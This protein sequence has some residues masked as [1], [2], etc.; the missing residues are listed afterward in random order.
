VNDC[1][2]LFHQMKISDEAQK[3]YD[4]LPPRC[5]KTEKN[6]A[7]QMRCRAANIKTYKDEL[8]RAGLIQIQL[9]RNGR[10]GNPRH[11]IIKF[12]KRR[13]SPI[14]KH[15]SRSFC[16]SEW[17]RLGRNELVECYLKSGWNIVPFAE[18]AKKPVQGL[19]V[20][21]WGRMPAAE[22]I[23]FFFNR[24]NLNLGL[25]VCSHLMVV[26][27]DAKDSSW[28]RDRNFADTLTVSTA[29]GFHFYFRSDPVIRTS[30]RTI[31]DI[32]TRCRHSFV[33]LPGS[34]HPSGAILKDGKN[35]VILRCPRLSPRGCG[36]RRS[37]DMAEVCTPAAKTSLK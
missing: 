2:T 8:E 20:R 36:T 25:V 5:W 31:P 1:F 22:K 29:R 37:G 17:G 26:D 13:R 30:S 15:I 18:R 19:S 34:T 12:P 3:L 21:E 7:K 23:D 10:R 28:L 6:L 4:L 33:L 9:L 32:D 24:P 11:E 16:F 27:I 14:C 35:R